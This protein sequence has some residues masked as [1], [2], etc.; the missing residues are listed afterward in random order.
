M[1]C[2][3]CREKIPDNTRKYCP[4][5]GAL[6]KN[7]KYNIDDTKKYAQPGLP[8]NYEDFYEDKKAQNQSYEDFYGKETNKQKKLPKVFPNIPKSRKASL[9]IFI[10]ILLFA[11]TVSVFDELNYEENIFSNE[12]IVYINTDA[13]VLA[14]ACSYI[15]CFTDFDKDFS[16]EDFDYYTIIDWQTV[17]SE[18]FSINDSSADNGYELAKNK[19]NEFMEKSKHSST[20]D[21]SSGVATLD[22]V[23]SAD[24]AT[25]TEAC[26]KIS[27]YCPSIDIESVKALFNDNETYLVTGEISFIDYTTQQPR[28][29]K[30]ALVMIENGD[31]YEVVYDNIFMDAFLKFVTGTEEAST[32]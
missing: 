12:E 10:A 13:T 4:E 17:F 9:L 15:T 30:I 23:V 22:F 28:T 27:T 5:C 6:I 14:D 18:E 29:E 26:K 25:F 1:R 24:E 8:N 2:K 7:V 21:Y 3:E 11:F 19:F 20:I 32:Q 16:F 31:F